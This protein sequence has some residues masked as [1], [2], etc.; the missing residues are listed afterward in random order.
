[1]T[2]KNPSRRMTKGLSLS[3]NISVGIYYVIHPK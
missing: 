2:H 3:L 1:M